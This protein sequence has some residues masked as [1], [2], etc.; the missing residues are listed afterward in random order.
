VNKLRA[1]VDLTRVGH[2]IML[3]I[4]IFIGAMIAGGMPAA[5][6][7]IFAFLTAL[8]LE[9]GTFALNDYFDYEVDKKNRRMDR[10][11]V[12]GDISPQFALMTYVILSP[13]GIVSS[14]MV[15][16][17][18]FYIALINLI[19]ATL[20]DAKLK[21]IKVVGNFYIA[22]TMAIPF[23]FGAVA[24]SNEIPAI[25]YFF[26]LLAFLSGAGRE[27]VKDVM[28]FEGDRLRN[29]K[30]FPYY[31]GREASSIVA[32]ILISIAVLMSVIPFF[33]NFDARYYHNIPFIILLSISDLIFLYS[34]FLI[35]GRKEKARKY[36]L[37]AMVVALIA[38]L[39]PSLASIK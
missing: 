18:C 13:L 3:C 39:F 34:I 27:I 29:T 31:I 17:S 32:S 15:N 16:L 9:M 25:I 23:I 7:F 5:T 36:T 26:A 12:R 24:V 8:F 2:G 11:L 38:F 28:D 10:P 22:F 1:F 30:S 19:V 21:E 20:Y 35:L 14:I 37:L 33:F 4:A 6:K